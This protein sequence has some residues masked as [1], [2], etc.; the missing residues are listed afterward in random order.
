MS[1]QKI[2]LIKQ[3]IIIEGDE[4]LLEPYEILIKEIGNSEYILKERDSKG[5]IKVSV[6][7]PVDK[8]IA[9]IEEA[10]KSGPI[11][12]KENETKT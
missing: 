10:Y 12:I 4:N 9:S 5:E 8:Y 1:K 6:I 7:I 2:G 11:N 3:K